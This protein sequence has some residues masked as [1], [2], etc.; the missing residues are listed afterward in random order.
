MNEKQIEKLAMQ[1]NELTIGHDLRVTIGA[2]IIEL[3]CDIVQ[4][5]DDKERSYIRAQFERLIVNTLRKAIEDEMDDQ[6]IKQETIQ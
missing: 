1:I 6:D 4:L 5:F 2:L 3:A